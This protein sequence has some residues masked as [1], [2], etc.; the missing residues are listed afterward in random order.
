MINIIPVTIYGWI[1]GTQDH[2]PMVAWYHSIMCS[3]LGHLPAIRLH[4]YQLLLPHLP[5]SEPLADRTRHNK[6]QLLA[7][8][9]NVVNVAQIVA[10]VVYAFRYVIPGE[11]WDWALFITARFL[12][13][14]SFT[15]LLPMKVQLDFHLND[16]AG[17]AVKTE[18]VSS[19]V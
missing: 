18:M 14:G 8:Y 2:V 3:L 12:I 10:L 4:F 7:W 17:S 5:D 13:S 19:F 6:G 15:L 9:G 11:L 1:F 16:V